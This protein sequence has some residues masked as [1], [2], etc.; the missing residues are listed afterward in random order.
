MWFFQSFWSCI[1]R[2]SEWILKFVAPFFAF[3]FTSDVDLLA[4]I[5]GKTLTEKKAQHPNQKRCFEIYLP[6]SYPRRWLDAETGPLKTVRGDFFLLT[7][8]LDTMKLLLDPFDTFI[9]SSFVSSPLLSLI[10]SVML[11]QTTL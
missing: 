4:S 6:V 1:E 7:T 8:V 9:I 3:F 2:F 5:R 11:F 10:I